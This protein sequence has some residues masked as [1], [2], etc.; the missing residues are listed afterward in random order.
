M[1]AGIRPIIDSRD[2][3]RCTACGHT[4]TPC[5]QFCAQCGK[6]ILG[7][8]VVE[9]AATTLRQAHSCL[10][11]DLQTLICDCFFPA[12]GIANNARMKGQLTSHRYSGPT[13]TPGVYIWVFRAGG[14]LRQWK[15][16]KEILI[17]LSEPFA[18]AYKFVD[19]IPVGAKFEWRDI[20]VKV[21]EPDR[22]L[23]E[24]FVRFAEQY[25]RLTGK[26]ATVVRCF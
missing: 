16:V 6:Q 11:G 2:R 19:E 22:K 4:I 18:G 8:A 20:T 17:D 25:Q 5:A 9:D 14:I 15:F 1:H 21:N 10:W 23:I 7:I 26:R 3:S 12:L 13:T 24:D